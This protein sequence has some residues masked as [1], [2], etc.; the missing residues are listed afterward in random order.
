VARKIDRTGGGGRGNGLGLLAGRGSEKATA[1]KRRRRQSAAVI[2]DPSSPPQYR[3]KSQ[4]LGS[5]CHQ[6]YTTVHCTYMPRCSL[7]CTIPSSGVNK[8]S[9][10]AGFCP[11]SSHRHGCCRDVQKYY[12][13]TRTGEDPGS[14]GATQ[15]RKKKR[16]KVTERPGTCLALHSPWKYAHELAGLS[17]GP[18][19]PGLDRTRT[20]WLA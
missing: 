5:R 6:V 4:S 10:R 14:E 19:S 18:V 17:P 16:W 9:D 20:L 11:A 13:R 1:G 7:V 3:S 15:R 2:W 8:A 12:R